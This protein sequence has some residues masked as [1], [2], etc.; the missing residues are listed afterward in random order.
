MVI[1]LL[2]LFVSFILAVYCKNVKQHKVLYFILFILFSS[3]AGLRYRVGTDSFMYEE[4][5]NY[6]PDLSEL[7]ISNIFDYKLEPLYIL[8]ISICKSLCDDYLFFQIVTAFIVNAALF[9]FFIQNSKNP[10]Q[11][12]FVYLLI[13]YLLLNCEFMRQAFAISVF[14]LLAYPYL[15]NRKIIKYYFICLIPCF[16]HNSLFLCLIFPLVHL[17]KL[18]FKKVLIISLTLFV[19]SVFFPIFKMLEMIIPNEISAAYKIIAYSSTVNNY[20][21]NF[22]IS[23]LYELSVIL[24]IYRLSIT[25]KLSN[26]LIVYIFAIVLSF[27]HDIFSRLQYVLCPFYIVSLVDAI[28]FISKYCKGRM[29]Q[30]SFISVIAFLPTLMYYNH[31]YPGTNL[32]VYYKF[33]PYSSYFNP[34][35]YPP[36]ESI[37]NGETQLLYIFK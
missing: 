31:R 7:K 33:F 28:N 18:S 1:Y 27:S 32:K 14:Y 35:K 12:I 37:A 30:I 36:R 23:K 11:C 13:F 24:F 2:L 15:K 34:E 17:I 4:M 22:I 5:F 26:F 19:V 21:L 9:K 8:Y 25:N 16:L 6:F 10:F 3:Y 29:M 20:N